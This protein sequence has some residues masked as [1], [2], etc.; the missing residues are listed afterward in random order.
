MLEITFSVPDDLL[1]W[2]NLQVAKGQFANA[3]EYLRY[4]V[5]RDLGLTESH[6]L[7]RK[8]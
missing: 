6:V 8:D 4:L 3:S 5:A 1:D 2:I 7:T